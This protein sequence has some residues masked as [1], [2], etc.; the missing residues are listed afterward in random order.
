MAD[1]AGAAEEEG[2]GLAILIDE[3]QDL[4]RDELTT[5]CVIAHAAAQDDWPVAF[6]FA[7]LP[8]LPRILAEAR[9][10]AERFRYVN[11]HELSD[12]AAAVA[13]TIPSAEEDAEWED[14]AVQ[15]VVT[16]SGRYPYFIQQFGPGLELHITLGMDAVASRIALD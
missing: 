7:G 10:H 6:A 4:S 2:V 3:A 14:A 11:V 1:L 9:S 5:L 15:V 16:A 12:V 8:S 13:L